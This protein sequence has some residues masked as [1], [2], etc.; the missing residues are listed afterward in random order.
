M[1][2]PEKVSCFPT[3]NKAIKDAKEKTISI[4]AAGCRILLRP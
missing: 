4:L 3:F 2:S 1:V